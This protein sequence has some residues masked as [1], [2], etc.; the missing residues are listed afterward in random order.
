MDS[1]FA[2]CAGVS[3]NDVK[4]ATSGSIESVQRYLA[5]NAVANL[6]NYLYSLYEALF[7]AGTLSGLLNG[8][9][10]TTFFT[11]PTPDATWFQIL[12]VFTPLLGVFS[13]MLGP[14]VS[15]RLHSSISL[16]EFY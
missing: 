4:D 10:V 7:D 14:F 9:I 11:N 5:W 1:S 15:Q 6:N 13:A 8:K 2:E 3:C 12:N 16:G